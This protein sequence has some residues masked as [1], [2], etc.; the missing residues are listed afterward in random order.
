MSYSG[1][2][3]SLLWADGHVDAVVSEGVVRAGFGRGAW[4]GGG[5][6][7]GEHK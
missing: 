1:F 5:G 4:S 6:V 7:V 2:S 3:L